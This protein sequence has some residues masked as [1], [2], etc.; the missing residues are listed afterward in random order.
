MSWVGLKVTLKPM[1]RIRQSVA[2]CL[3]CM[4]LL[5]CPVMAKKA[6]PEARVF[7]KGPVQVGQYQIHYSAFNST[8]IPPAVAEQYNLR[9]GERYGVV[10]IAIRDLTS[11]SPGK[12]TTAKVSGHVK[13]L[14]AQKN[15][16]KFAEVQEGDSIYY[17]AGFTFSDEELLKF[18]VD[19]T[20]LGSSLSETLNFEQMFYK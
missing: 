4:L 14:L 6:I 5:A 10:N 9:R 13:N 8:F 1:P 15:E 17:L 11:G 16:L 7:D 20:P 3:A 2:W 12:A 18:A 19:V